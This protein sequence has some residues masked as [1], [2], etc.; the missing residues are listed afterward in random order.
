MD[1][2]LNIPTVKL[3]LV[4]IPKPRVSKSVVVQLDHNL[5]IILINCA[6]F[7]VK[8]YIRTVFYTNSL[9]EYIIGGL[10]VVTI[11]KRTRLVNATSLT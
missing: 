8:F 5:T 11:P 9:F 7:S 2:T 4:F 10:I 1:D 3:Q 6:S